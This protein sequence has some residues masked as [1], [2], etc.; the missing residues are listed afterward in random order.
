[1]L[2]CCAAAYGFLEVH[3]ITA[4]IQDPCRAIGVL[5][6]GMLAQGL[7]LSIVASLAGLNFVLLVLAFGRRWFSKHPSLLPSLPVVEL[8]GT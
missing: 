5:L 3:S 1:M 4:T 6:A 8:A 7:R 2:C